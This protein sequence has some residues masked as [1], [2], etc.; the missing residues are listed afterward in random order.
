ME[1]AR[2]VIDLIRRRQDSGGYQKENWEGTF[3][4]YLSVVR[5]NPKVARNAFQRMYD[6]ILS[7]GTE[8]IERHRE[9]LVRYHFFDDPDNEIG[10]AHV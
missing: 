1:E 9:T 10:R 5:S 4:D 6:M 8:K 7:Y 3:E 2:A